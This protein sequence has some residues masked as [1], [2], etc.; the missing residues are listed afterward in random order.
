MARDRASR[1]EAK[2]LRLFVAVDVPESVREMLAGAVASW[3]ERYPRAR[4]VPPENWHLTLKF[5]G[6]TW[7]RL[8][9]WVKES[10][11]E[12]ARSSAAFES[13]LDGLGAFRSPRQARVLWAGLEEGVQ[14]GEPRLHPSSHGGPLRAAGPARRRG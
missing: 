2:P 7:P 8:V 6:S 10:V 3:R 5:L 11:A 14:A 12:V 13:R 9:E 1:A 4:W